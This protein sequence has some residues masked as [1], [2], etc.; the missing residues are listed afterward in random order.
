MSKKEKDGRVVDCSVIEDYII[1]MDHN[2]QEKPKNLDRSPATK[3]FVKRLIRDTRD[4]N[5]NCYLSSPWSMIAS[6]SGW[7]FTIIIGSCVT[8]NP[9]VFNQWFVPLLLFSI[10]TSAISI[11]MNAIHV[12]NIVPFETPCALRK[13]EAPRDEDAEED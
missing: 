9:S 12:G 4:H 8:S 6:M 11:D 5:H 1:H 2:N 13:Y 7:F 3:G 10:A